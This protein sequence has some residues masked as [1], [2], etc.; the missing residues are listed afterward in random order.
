MKKTF[1]LIELLV[2]IAIIAILAA[3]L[4]PALNKARDK[5]REASCKSNVKNLFQFVFNYTDSNNDW[6]PVAKDANSAN[7]LFRKQRGWDYYFAV[8]ELAYDA[9]RQPATMLANKKKLTLLLCPGSSGVHA[10]TFN[11][12]NFSTYRMNHALGCYNDSGE[13][14]SD[15]P[16]V[17]DS[18]KKIKG[19]IKKLSSI[20][21]ASR[22]AVF[23]EGPGDKIDMTRFG[24]S[25]SGGYYFTYLGYPHGSRANFAFL[26]GHMTSLTQSDV[27]YDSMH[28]GI[29]Q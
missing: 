16:A 15:F 14:I 21:T 4:M 12:Y 7:A 26:D 20:H 23:G 19:D 24:M 11:T 22:V 18:S 13:P 25:F 2:V 3:M 5:A 1:T 8:N 27:N 28:S 29:V 6:I 17:N 10:E 9:E